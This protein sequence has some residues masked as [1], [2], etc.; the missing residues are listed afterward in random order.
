MYEGSVI[1]A[2]RFKCHRYSGSSLAV[3]DTVCLPRQLQSIRV[4]VIRMLSKGRDHRFPLLLFQFHLLDISSCECLQVL[5]KYFSASASAFQCIKYSCRYT[6]TEN[7]VSLT[8]SC[9]AFW[10]S[11]YTFKQGTTCSQPA[12]FHNLIEDTKWTKINMS[13]NLKKMSC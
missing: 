4:F 1:F 10:Q 8:H 13:L 3:N 12:D 5:L 7:Q 2:I 6:A 11:N 9:F